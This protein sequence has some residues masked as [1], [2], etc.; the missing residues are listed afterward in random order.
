MYR[1]KKAAKEA[2]FKALEEVNKLSPGMH[3]FCS[4]PKMHGKK[5]YSRGLKQVDRQGRFGRLLEVPVCEEDFL[6]YLASLDMEE[7]GFVE[8]MG[9]EAK[10]FHE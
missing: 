3:L 4:V 10:F 8:L 5:G 1:S 7:I 9:R 6:S 2:F